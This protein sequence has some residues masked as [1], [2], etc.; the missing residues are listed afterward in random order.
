MATDKIYIV[1]LKKKE[2]LEGF[3]ADMASDGYKLSLK[4]PISR[5]THYFMEEEDAVEIRK[6]SRVIACERHPEQLGITPTPYGVINNEPYGTSG[7]FR[8]S[9]SF[10]DPNDKDWGKLSVAG[11]DAQ[12][13]KGTWGSGSGTNVVTDTYEMFN[14][15]KH[16][17]VVIVD[18][19]VSRDC[20]EWNSPS[21]GL[22]RFVE[23]E[24][25]NELNTYVSSID[26]DGQTIPTGSYLPNYP[27]NN[28]NQSSH[29]IHVAGTVAGQWYGW[30]NEANIYSMGI[31][32]GGGGAT[33]AGPSTFLCFD[34]LRAFH[35]YK[36]VNPETGHRN[37]T[38]TNH[39]WGYSYDLSLIHISEPTRPY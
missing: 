34:Y 17:D 38:V 2:D 20:A 13:R 24:W 8:K 3:Y 15:G 5:N 23:Y 12:R 1:T 19:P 11:T 28:A 29:G 22:S 36:P 27:D 4:R 18:Q 35:R 14:N 7:Q 32:S 16:V 31:L 10:T 39:S 37:P 30:A 21:T 9:G 25:Y 33:F 26:D 6:D